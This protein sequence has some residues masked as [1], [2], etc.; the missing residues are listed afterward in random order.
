M[1]IAKLPGLLGSLDPATQD[2][3]LGASFFIYARMS[4]R[5]RT[6]PG[7]ALIQRCCGHARLGVCLT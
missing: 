3:T 4:L 6:R 5:E 7:L 1:N 2:S